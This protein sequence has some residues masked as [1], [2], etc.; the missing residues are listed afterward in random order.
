MRS[1]FLSRFSTNPV[2][3][4]AL[5]ILFAFFLHQA[6][7]F[8]VH[9]RFTMDEFTYLHATWMV[10]QGSVPY[11]DFAMPHMPL[12]EFLLAPL[13]VLLGD[14]PET[15]IAARLAMYALAAVVVISMGAM[16]RRFGAAGIALPAVFLFSLSEQMPRL[17]EV[18]PDVLGL[19]LFAAAIGILRAPWPRP[20]TRAAMSGA[21][22]V[23][24]VIGSVKAGLFGLGYFPAIVVMWY[25]ARERTENPAVN[26]VAVL[27]GG[28]AVLIVALVGFAVAGIAAEPFEL[29]V[30]SWQYVVEERHRTPWADKLRPVLR[31]AGLLI[32]LAAIGAAG[33]VRAMFRK[34][35]PTGD[36]VEEDT[37]G[38]LI[39]TAVPFSLLSFAVQPQPLSYS[40]LPLTVLVCVLAARGAELLR[41]AANKVISIRLR[42]AAL[43]AMGLVL[44]AFVASEY[45]QIRRMRGRD[46]FSNRYQMSVLSDVLR[47]TGPRDAV[48][49]VVGGYVF[50][51]HAYPQYIFGWDQLDREGEWLAGQIIVELERSECV[52]WMY[53]PW[54][55]CPPKLSRYLR[56]NYVPY[57]EDLWLLGRKFR[58]GDGKARFHA[59]KG[60]RYFVEPAESLKSGWL[61]IDGKRV[62]EDEFELEKGVHTV[63]YG[64]K[65]RPFHILW[66]PRDGRRYTPVESDPH[67]FFIL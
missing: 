7:V 35:A 36:D 27:A 17:I 40:A 55:R 31:D 15:L 5:T 37:V 60:G 16:N 50:R 47:V 64:G 32:A 8:S 38:V 25:A 6:I 39:L 21:L 66:L 18:R 46:N 12:L 59:N 34:S 48:F 9:K 26:P 30:A 53:G 65:T 10:S 11:R 57:N 41:R 4:S 56:E 58:D 42:A 62:S 49:D 44:V 51:P 28:A 33:T 67:Y 23:L 52:A 61:E 54:K 14:R 13:F 29:M 1:R 45:A 19:S 3:L 20:L 63:R 22:A 2:L 43:A 24:A